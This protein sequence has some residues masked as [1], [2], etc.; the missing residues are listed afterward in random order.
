[1]RQFPVVGILGARQ[2]GKTTLARQLAEA[3]RGPVTYFD[4][5]SAEDL[6]RLVDPMLALRP[7][8]GLIVLDEVQRRPDL[9]T[10]L[11]VLVDQAR[12]RRRSS[13]LGRRRDARAIERRDGCNEQV[14]REPRHVH[15]RHGELRPGDWPAV[16]VE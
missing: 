3:H 16:G 1:M 2:V 4:L 11:R 15:A 10:Q 8:T 7:L 6:A 9:F 12:P 14:A 13:R 5:E